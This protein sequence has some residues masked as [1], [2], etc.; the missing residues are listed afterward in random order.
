MLHIVVAG[1]AVAMPWNAV[2]SRSKALTVEFE[3]LRIATVATLP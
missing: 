2:L 1:S 3:A